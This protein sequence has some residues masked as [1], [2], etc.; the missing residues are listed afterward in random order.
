M[1]IAPPE[2]PRTGYLFGK[3][4]YFADMAAKSLGYCRCSSG[5]GLI[6]LCEVSIGT[7][8]EYF[9]FNYDADFLPT[10][11]N[12]TKGCGMTA[13]PQSCYKNMDGVLVPNGNGENTSY[14]VIY[15]F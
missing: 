2:A 3:G 1:R 11:F 15:K 10:G 13:P 9:Q 6:L 12:S 8:K 14:K 4:A 5:I 7:P